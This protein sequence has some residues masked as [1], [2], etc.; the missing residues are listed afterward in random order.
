MVSGF[1]F[2]QIGNYSVVA[3]LNVKPGGGNYSSSCRNDVQV[4]LVYSDFPRIVISE[5]LGSIASDKYTHYENIPLKVPATSKPIRVEVSASR[6]WKRKIGGCG[7]N[8]SFNGDVR[9]STQFSSCL[10]TYTD[11]MQWWDDQLTIENTPILTIV[12]PGDNSLPTETDIIINS[13]TGF[14]ASEYNWQYSFDFTNPNAWIDMPQYNGKA[15]ITTNAKAILGADAGKYHGKQIY[16]RQKACSNTF[17]D[18]VYYVIRQS[19][20]LIISENLIETTCFNTQ[21]GKLIMKFDR[22]L[23]EGEKFTFSI[24]EFDEQSQQWK[25]VVCSSQDSENI[26][27]DNTNSYTFPCDFSIG[28]YGLDFTGF[29]N[30][31]STNPPNDA[32]HPFIF[33]IT[34]PEPVNFSL[35]KT[36]V[37]CNGGNDGTL[38]IAASGGS[39]EGYEYSLDN[40]TSWIPFTDPKSRTEILGGL[41][42]TSNLPLVFNIKVKDKKGCIA[43]ENAIDKI[44]TE[45]IS[46]PDAP[47]TLNYTYKSNPTFNGAANGKIVASINGGT[48]NDNNTYTYEW[49]NSSGATI[50]TTAQYNA[51]DKTYNI[52]LE[53]APA[54]EYKLTVTDK[55]YSVATNKTACSIIES[56][57]TLTQPDPIAITIAE[58]QP[59][60]CNTANHDADFGNPDKLSDGVLKATVVGGIQPYQYIWSKFNSFSNSWDIL[61]DITGDTAQNLS[62]GNYSLNVID[63]NG[64]TQGTYSTTDLV[65]AISTTKEIVEPA[66]LELSFTSGNVSCHEGNNGWATVNTTGGSA[67]Y[68]YTWYNTGEGIVNSNKISQLTAG[69]YT[70]EVID[71]KGCFT[72]SSIEITQPS[73][74]LA[75]KYT[76]TTPPT[77]FGA[78]NGKIVAEISGGTPKIDQSYNYKWKNK[79]G[80]VQI[81]TVQIIDNKYVI[82]LDNI[83]ADEYYLTVTDA[84]YNE[85]TN[86][87]NNCSVLE[88]KNE[89]KDPD[90]LKVVFEIVRSISCNAGNEFG[91]DTDITPKDG[92]RDESQDGILTA[93]VTG[94]VTL[95]ASQN[96]GFPYFYYW[97][98]QQADGSWAVLTDIQGETASNLSH[99]NYALNVED[100]NG[101]ILG[102]YANNQLVTPTDAIQFMQEPPKLS[103]TIT[104]GD[105][106]CNGGN[107]GW[108]KANVIGGTPPYEYKWSNDIETDN[109]DI[110]KAGEYW[111]FVTDAKGCTTQESV[112]IVQPDAPLAVKYTQVLN[113]S[114]YKATNGKIVVE[115]SGG[116]I[117]TNNTYWYEWKNSKGISQTTTAKYANGIY[118]IT[119]NGVPDETYSLT[120]RDAN[121]NAATNKTSCNVA[122]SNITLVEPEPLK[123]V[124]EIERT[125]SCNVSNEFGNETDANPQDGQ[126]DESQDGI[127]TAHVTGGIQLQADQNNGLPYFYTWKKKQKDGSWAIWNDQDQTAE[128]LSEG[129][130]ALNIED[131]NGIKLGTYVNNLLV[132]EIDVTQYMAEPEKLNLTFTKLNA[133]CNN[134]DDGWAEAHV[135]GGTAPY[136]YEWTNGETTSKIENIT[137]NNYFVLVTD[138]KGCVVQG[139][140]FVGD[141]KGILTTEIIKNPTCYQGNDAS[142]QLNVTGGNLP[143]TYLW[144]TGATTKDLNNITAGNYEVTIKC[145]DCC[146]YKKRF[147]L[148]DPNPINVNLGPDR[149]LC[150]NQVLDLDASITDPNAEYNWTSTNGFTS[151]QAKVSLTKAGIYT[152]K[153]TSALGCVGQD[154]IVIKTS[155]TDISSEFLL[156]SQAYIDEEVILVNTSNPFGEST[157]WT[158]PQGVNIVEQK[159]KYITLKFNKTGVYNIGLKQTQG[160]CFAE[161][162]KNITVEERS[163][164]PNASSVAKY[165]IDFIVTPNPNNG[166]FKAIVNLENNSAINLRLFSATGQYTTI[167]K[168]E[169]GRKNYE[170]DFNTSLPAG[171]YIIVLETEQQT[172]VKKIII[173]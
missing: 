87:I 129:T 50:P 149:T 151:N 106:Y 46:Q 82:T 59:I 138:A 154:E 110:L 120:V 21:D 112:T 166:N 2:A 168:K 43:Q 97:K 1:G 153:V 142:I 136:T 3:K 140:I 71:A 92:Q 18:P 75:L 91:N 77:F 67:P 85:A 84:N 172:L 126:R 6:N 40:G 69:I 99:G 86:Q 158:I 156:S 83:P 135:S 103:M 162:N 38:T 132:K 94:G 101:I 9:T 76:E 150:Y 32:D 131:A 104:K 134:G 147:V 16:F 57:Q 167:Q 13:H 33:N 116:T 29:I 4:K 55:N 68:S 118:E 22:P 45:T 14:L 137:T 54:E 53:N 48:I 124:F 12:Q 127:L 51:T 15:S 159:E 98:K 36:N 169:S 74:A 133:S 89:L 42:L 115:V 63:A 65:T 95:L 30:G 34:A 122:N 10:N 78:T 20:P 11:I 130:Y 114:F 121:Y 62:Q 146:V 93:H 88:S 80:A 66:K 107:D 64:I 47:L 44:L 155:K 17:S 70:V 105:V 171:I 41:Y 125:I 145:P 25:G 8:G 72:K 31:S 35:S 58:S 113:P 143:Y 163:T 19:A 161:Y 160:E 23:V 27:L 102:T 56:S 79:A 73:A 61:S 123:V 24:R 108:A 90:P 128:N 117:F 7:G 96:N 81:T 26:S 170:I 173:N 37:N 152:V 148:K 141:P 109:N 49:K 100:R 111:V 52:T 139:S 39:K 164:L 119:L 5:N 60:S 157:A 28:K 165:I 144:N